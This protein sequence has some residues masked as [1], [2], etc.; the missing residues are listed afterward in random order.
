M[1]TRLILVIAGIIIAHLT[2]G[3]YFAYSKNNAD[4]EHDTK[5]SSMKK[6]FD[7]QKEQNLKEHEK[8]LSSNYGADKL[9]RVALDPRLDI[10]LALKKMFENVLPD[11]WKIE[12]TVN[13][14][15]EFRVYVSAGILKPPE[16]LSGYLKQVFSRIGTDYVYEI[17]FS[18]GEDAYFID[19]EELQKIDDWE[20]AS[21]AIIER[22]CFSD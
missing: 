21:P 15:T 22:Y 5:L 8:I 6:E 4:I 20:K 7:Q 10:R 12:V 3:M 16:E 11:H 19:R 1:T 18:K 2:I 9:D 17:V 14:F 13:R